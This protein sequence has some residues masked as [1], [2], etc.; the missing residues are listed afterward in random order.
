MRGQVKR[1]IRGYL[2]RKPLIKYLH[3]HAGENQ[4]PV[5]NLP[6]SSALTPA[7]LYLLH[8]CS[9]TFPLEGGREYWQEFIPGGY[10]NDDSKDYWT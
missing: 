10:Q 3:C 9:R 8:P 1:K 6:P 2:F 5:K 7:S 4:H